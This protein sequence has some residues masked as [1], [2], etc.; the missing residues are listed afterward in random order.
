MDEKQVRDKIAECIEQSGATF[1]GTGHKT[2]LI[3]SL[4]DLFYEY[5]HARLAFE[6]VQAS[7]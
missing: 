5:V 3:F 1:P 7:R 6:E 4:E 2:M